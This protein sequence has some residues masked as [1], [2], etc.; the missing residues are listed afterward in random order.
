MCGRYV[1]ATHPG[2]LMLEFGAV[3]L[4]NLEHYAPDYNVAPTKPVPAVVTMNGSRLVVEMGWGLVPSWAKDPTIGSRMINARVETAAEKPTFRRA[5]SRRRCLL[6][7]DGYYEWLKPAAG[8]GRTG[9][10]PYYIHRTD[11]GLLAFAGLYEHWLG[12]DGSELLTAAILTGAATPDL[13]RIHDRMPLTVAEAGRDAWLDPELQESEEVMALLERE[14]VWTARPVSTAVNSVRNNGGALIEA[15]EP[16]PAA[17][18]PAQKGAARAASG[19][20]SDTGTGS[21]GIDEP[22]TL[23]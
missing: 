13:A 14:P 8:S 20:L 7:A 4:V 5:L 9:K 1:V 15:Y 22:E 11:G 2:Q 19:A 3:G 23:F 17:V 21:A 6:P 12:S 18:S 16:P 10:Q